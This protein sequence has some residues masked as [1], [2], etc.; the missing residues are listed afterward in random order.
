MRMQPGIGLQRAKY[1]HH[2][3]NAKFYGN[4]GD[5]GVGK[6]IGRCRKTVAKNCGGYCRSICHRFC[7]TPV[8]RDSAP[9]RIG[10]L[11][12]RHDNLAV[13][14]P[15]DAMRPGD[16]DQG[17]LRVGRTDPGDIRALIL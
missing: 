2:W 13:T 7:G 8:P 9:K 15:L 10:I 6:E 5:L 17:F 1:R 4:A 16:Q 12:L 3:K 14:P 11:R